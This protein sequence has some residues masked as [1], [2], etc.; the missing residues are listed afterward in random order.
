MHCLD[1][2]LHVP[3][4]APPLQTLVH[5]VPFCQTPF[6]SQVCGMRLLHCLALGEHTPAQ[7]PETHA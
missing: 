3:E 2:G 7:A 4:H 6:G 1:A 5:A